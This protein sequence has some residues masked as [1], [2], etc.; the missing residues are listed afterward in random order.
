[1]GKYILLIFSVFLLIGCDKKK[2]SL[3]DLVGKT[4]NEKIYQQLG[5]KIETLEG[6]NNKRW[7]AYFPVTNVTIIEDKTTKKIISI[8]SGRHPME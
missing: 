7:V 3:P 1:M 6:T 8:K 2:Q 4:Y 5:Y